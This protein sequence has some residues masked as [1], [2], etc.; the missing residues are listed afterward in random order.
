MPNGVVVV[1][2]LSACPSDAVK[3]EALTGTD[4]LSRPPEYKFSPP[5]SYVAE[6]KPMEKKTEKAAERDIISDAHGICA[7]LKAVGA[8]TCDVKVNVF[9]ASFIDATAATTPSDAQA[10]CKKVTELTRQKD[11]PFI[12]QGWQL[13]IFSPLGAGTRPMAVCQL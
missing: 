1:K 11:S 4:A 8:T 13:K 3:S 5:K 7:L 6:P 12:G 9:S 2:R 10:V